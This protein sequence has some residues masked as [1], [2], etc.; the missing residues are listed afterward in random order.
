[1]GKLGR[2][3]SAGGLGFAGKFRFQIPALELTATGVMFSTHGDAQELNEITC[4]MMMMISAG[5][6]TQQVLNKNE[7][8]E[9]T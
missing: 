7:A 6:D 2:R 3:P 9:I 8:Q 4:M 1:M 5:P